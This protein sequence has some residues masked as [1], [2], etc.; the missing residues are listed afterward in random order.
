MSLEVSKV[1]KR[2]KWIQADQIFIGY[3]QIDDLE[4]GLVNFKENKMKKKLQFEI[5]EIGIIEF[6]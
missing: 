6:F 4:W 5:E 2:Y 3:N 1:Q